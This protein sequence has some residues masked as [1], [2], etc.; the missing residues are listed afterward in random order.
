MVPSFI[1]VYDDPTQEKYGAV[2]LNGTASAGP[3]RLTRV[4]LDGGGSVASTDPATGPVAISVHPWEIAL[5]PPDTGSTGSAQNRLA[6]E[7]VS[8]AHVGNR[9]RIGLAAG[10][11]LVAEVTGAAVRQLALEP[12]VRVVA[13]WKAAAT[14]VVS[15]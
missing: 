4:E 3:D 6:A 5:E 2:V 8:V 7:V 9:V 1:S 11:P 13:T 10:Q 12:G 14:R 15:R